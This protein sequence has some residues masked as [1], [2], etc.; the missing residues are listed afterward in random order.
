MAEYVRCTIGCLRPISQPARLRLVCLSLVIS[1]AFR[2]EVRSPSD[3]D[4]YAGQVTKARGQEQIP[5]NNYSE[6]T[7]FGSF[8]SSVDER[9]AHKLVR[10]EDADAVLAQLLERISDLKVEI[11]ETLSDLN[12]SLHGKPNNTDLMM[13][14]KTSGP[15]CVTSFD[16]SH[17]RKVCL[18]GQCRCS[19]MYSQVSDCTSRANLTSEVGERFQAG[20]WCGVP[21]TD[22]QLFP[23]K[24]KWGTNTESFLRQAS[25]RGD[26]DLPTMAEFST[27]ALVGSSRK[28]LKLHQGAE[29]NAHAAVFRFNDAPTAGYETHVGNK[30]TV[31]VQNVEY[32]GFRETTGEIL[33]HYTDPSRSR[34]T[35]CLRSDIRK[36]SHPLLFYSSGYFAAVLPPAPQDPS[37][38]TNP[39]MSA[40]FFGVMIALHLCGEVSIYGFD[41]SREHYYNKNRKIHKKELRNLKPFTVR[42]AWTFERRCLRLLT[43][44]NGSLVKAYPRGSPTF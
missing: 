38:G 2:E 44:S 4:S 14:N 43:E 25:Q 18:G 15:E 22:N 3:S 34:L 9:E 29:I 21:F 26:P 27:C 31:R 39:K 35:K 17:P 42:H 5:L 16:C 8:E 6:V 40:G 7:A 12:R 32:C 30:T 10:I 19:I 11:G 37:R 36:I 33:V 13:Q 20:A 23:P 1:A 24:R 28:M 41:Q